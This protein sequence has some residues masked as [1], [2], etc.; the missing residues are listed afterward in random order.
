MDR[1]D[2][3]YDY[4]LPVYLKDFEFLQD[5]Y[6]KIFESMARALQNAGEDQGFIISGCE[7]SGT[8]VSEG[9]I[10]L[11]GEV[12]YFAGATG[13]GG[14]LITNYLYKTEGVN[15]DGTRTGGNNQSHT[16]WKTIRAGVTTTAP[17][18]PYLTLA[19]NRFKNMIWNFTNPD[20]ITQST[21]NTPYTNVSGNNLKWRKVGNYLEIKGA[22]NNTTGVFSGVIFSLNSGYKPALTTKVP[23]VIDPAF[24]YGGKTANLLIEW[25]GDV[26][27]ETPDTNPT[28]FNNIFINVRIPLD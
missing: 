20:W 9:L 26:K 24:G 10:Y 2:F 14:T 23:V 21:L 1:L 22:I 25:G 16:A 28:G 11:N 18:A 15:S 4:T 8:T 7:K 27:L 17:S 19:S 6:K 3:N 5:T 13:I 12:L